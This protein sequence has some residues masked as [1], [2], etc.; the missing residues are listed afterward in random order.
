VRVDQYL[1]DRWPRA[2]ALAQGSS[3]SRARVQQALKLGLVS[4]NGSPCS[5]PSTGLRAGDVVIASLPDPEPL[6]RAEPE[7]GLPLVVVWEDH[8]VA[9]VWKPAGMVVHPSPGHPRGTLVNAMLHHLGLPAMEA[10]ELL[11]GNVVRKKRR[12]GEGEDGDDDDDEDDD[13]DFDDEEEE[14]EQAAAAPPQTSIRPNTNKNVVRPGIVHRLDR[15]TTGLMAVAKTDAA[16]AA[17]CA[18]FKARTVGRVYVSVVAPLEAVGSGGS[19]AGAGTIRGQIGA[20]GRVATNVARDP[21]DRLRMAAA[22]LGSAR[23][24]AAAS[25]WRVLGG[26]GRGQEAAEEAVRKA[27]VGGGWTPQEEGGGGGRGGG[28]TAP[29]ASAT[30]APSPPLVVEWKLE[31]GRTHQIRVHARHLGWPLLG[32]DAYGP[33]NAAAAKALV[34]AASASGRK[35][36]RGGDSGS[37][38][39]STTTRVAA[40]KAALDAFGR[41]ALHARHLAFDHPVTGERLEFDCGVPDDMRELLRALGEALG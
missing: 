15:G 18:Q 21:R 11:S 20:E 40:V 31:T 29:A 9:V 6:A 19:S 28:R 34:A 27:E 2:A 26:A 13:G 33:G 39:T 25:N 1:A 30:P 35:Q 4:V 5:K 38:S 36:S 23:G 7:A 17:I 41:P 3:A 14:E 24:R 22:P 10:G 32:D 12:G 8:H 16:H 37:G